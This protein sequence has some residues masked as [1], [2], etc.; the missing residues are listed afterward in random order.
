MAGEGASAA[1]QETQLHDGVH[2]QGDGGGHQHVQRPQPRRQG[3]LRPGLQRR[4]QGWPGA[5]LLAFHQSFYFVWAGNQ[6]A[7]IQ[8]PSPRSPAVPPSRFP[9]PRISPVRRRI[10]RRASPVRHRLSRPRLSHSRARRKRTRRAAAAALP[11]AGRVGAPSWRSTGHHP[12][13]PGLLL[14]HFKFHIKMVSYHHPQSFQVFSIF[15]ASKF[16]LLQF[17]KPHLSRI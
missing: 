1:A 12:R 3:R 4:P 5:C 10:S 13:R 9:Q 15:L 7:Q 11:A 6:Q 8:S 16:G 2:A 17:A 14:G